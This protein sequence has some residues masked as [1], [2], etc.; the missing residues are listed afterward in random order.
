MRAFLDRLARLFVIGSSFYPVP[1]IAVTSAYVQTMEG[2]DLH[3]VAFVIA[4]PPDV[5]S[6][7]SARARGRFAEAGLPLG[8]T[9]GTD[10]RLAA[11]LTL[12]LNTQTLTDICPG[13]V[14][15]T[16]SLTLIE[17][18]MIT[19][20]SAL[21]NDVTWLA[22]TGSQVRKPVPLSDLEQDL[23]TFIEQFIADFRAANAEIRHSKS[24][25]IPTVSQPNPLPSVS[26][27]AGSDMMDPDAGL[28]ELQLDQ[29]RISVSAGRFSHSLTA[30]ALQQLS[31]AGHVLTTG[32]D[33]NNQVTL[34]VE[35][36]QRTLED[37]CPGTVLYESGLYLVEEV[38]I[39]RNRRVSIWSD[40]WMRETTQVITPRSQQQL[41]SDQD[42]LLRQFLDSLHSQ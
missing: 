26:V 15:Y 39:R 34:G 35:L 7:L 30:L 38:Q 23:E 11:T 4:A 28:K 10:R 2:L 41:E 14:L 1:V 37:R 13:Y 32:R 40:T 22:H 33:H 8:E 27:T 16:P 31:E 12:T 25:D 18:V 36:T 19:R 29:L 17:P 20:N 24:D 6:R 21:R 9:D 5:R 3:Q 42:A